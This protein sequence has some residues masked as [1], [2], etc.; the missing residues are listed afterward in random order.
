MFLLT[1]TQ[2]LWNYLVLFSSGYSNDFF[3]DK[4]LIPT[5]LLLFT[6]N[7]LTIFISKL[8]ILFLLPYPTYSVPQRC[9]A[10]FIIQLFF[11]NELNKSLTWS[12]QYCISDFYIDVEIH[13]EKQ[14]PLNAHA[15]V[16]CAVVLCCM[17]TL[18]CPTLC[19]S[20]IQLFSTFVS[21]S[22]QHNGL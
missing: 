5:L 17:G 6:C 11:L 3:S 10:H 22:L 16:N 20:H 19:D 9:A 13:Q 14:H 21:S 1:R 4:H 15:A 18:S 7:I 12:T 2:M 8:S